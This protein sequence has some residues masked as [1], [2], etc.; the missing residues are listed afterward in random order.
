MNFRILASAIPVAI[1][2]AL[3][4]IAP[5]WVAI[6][7][8]FVAT[9]VV[10][11]AN[12]KDRL[13][14]LLAVYG[15]VIVAVCAVAGI[16]GNNEKAYLASGPISD[17]LFFPLYLGS[18]I[19]RRPLVGGVAR[20]LVPAAT[21]RIPADAFVF[22]WLSVLWAFYNLSQGFFRFWLL[23]EL[24]VGEYIILSRLLNWPMSMVMLAI[25]A[26]FIYREARRHGFDLREW[27]REP[28]GER[29]VAVAEQA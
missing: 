14:G 1:F 2:F 20:E 10:T 7:V 11:Y 3:T 19:L 24:S 17:F 25:T 16:V 27:L 9:A 6:I 29:N 21:L 5:P 13:I 15:F 4:R 23:S 18:V 28:E 12:R 22:M 8:G 26:V